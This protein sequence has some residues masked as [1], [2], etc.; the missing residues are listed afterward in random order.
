MKLV[1]FLICSGIGYLLGHYLPDPL[2]TYVSILVSYHLFLAWLVI[3]AEHEGGLSLPV[4]QTVLTHAACLAVLIGL[5]MGRHHLPLL[6]L[7]RIFVPG[8][9]PFECKWLFSRDMA[10][11]KAQQEADTPAVVAA[12]SVVSTPEGAATNP[13]SDPPEAEYTADEHTAWIRYLADKRRAFRKPGLT[14]AEEYK[15]WREARA[16]YL[17]MLAQDQAPTQE[18]SPGEGVSE[19]V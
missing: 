6:G 14:V 5:A 1:V 11:K 13:D 4:L 15:A 12:A 16:R 10:K 17:A 7:V 18:Q 3:T 9:A 19:P 2:G 8:L